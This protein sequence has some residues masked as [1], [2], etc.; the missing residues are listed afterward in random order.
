MIDSLAFHIITPADIEAG[1]SVLKGAYG[2]DDYRPK[3]RRY[4][5]LQPDGWLIGFY[6]DTPVAIAGAVDYGPFAYIGMVGVHENWQR[7][8]FGMEIMRELMAR[9]NA[10]GCPISLLDATVAGAAVYIKLGF[11]EEGQTLQRMRENPVPYGTIPAS[12]KVMSTDDIPAV[13]AFDAP[14][15]GANRQQVLAQMLEEFPERG[16]IMRGENGEIRGYAIAQNSAIGPWIAQTPGDAE[17]LLQAALTLDYDQRITVNFPKSNEAV[18]ELLNRYG[19]QFSR[20]TAHM[21]H[22]GD[23][24]PRDTARLYGQ[25]SFAL[26]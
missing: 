1:N 2:G 9:L 16:F 18:D 24:D 12:V 7:R 13:A 15:F 6:Q 23:H 11:F 4:V 3:L 21:R 8:G 17:L 20:V 14:I 19:F 25:A 26:G 5:A 22:G 10:R